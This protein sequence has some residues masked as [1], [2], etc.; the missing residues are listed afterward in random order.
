[1]RYTTLLFDLDHTLFDFDTSEAEAFTAEL[2][3]TEDMGGELC[4]KI[5]IKYDE[6][7]PGESTWFISKKDFMPRSRL[8]SRPDGSAVQYILTNVIADPKLTADA[9][10]FKTPE[11]YKEQ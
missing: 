6:S 10:Q 1:M 4:Y 11:G 3:G 9:F 5:Y 7:G 2:K 8:S